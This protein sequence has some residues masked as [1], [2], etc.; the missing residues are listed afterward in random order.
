[1]KPIFE[2]AI[3]SQANVLQVERRL[4]Q[5]DN[6]LCIYKTQIIQMNDRIKAAQSPQI[7]LEIVDGKVKR[8]RYLN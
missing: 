5:V 6:F 7:I 2:R 1:M 3:S 8:G 4:K